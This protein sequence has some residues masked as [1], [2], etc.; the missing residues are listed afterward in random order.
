MTKLTFLLLLVPAVAVADKSFTG[1]KEITWD[2]GKDPKVSITTG[3]A[4]ITLTGTCTDI[5]ITGSDNTLTADYLDDF[6]VNG[7]NTKVKVGTL[8][9]IVINGNKN[10]VI[11]KKPKSGKAPDYQDNGKGNSVSKEKPQAPKKSK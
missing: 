11:Y 6:V 8:G 4:T 1:D 2:C 7:N 5:A 3:N 9:E 10:S